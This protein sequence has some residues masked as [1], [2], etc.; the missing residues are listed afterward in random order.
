[1]LD[2]LDIRRNQ[3]L[4]ESV[5]PKQLQNAFR[6]MERNGN[7]W[8]LGQDSRLDWAKDLDLP[9]I[10]INPKP[11]ILWWVG[12]APASEA[13][14]QK[15][16]REFVRILR[17]AKVNFAVLGTREQCTGDSA[18]RAGNEYLFAQMAQANIETLNDVQPPRIVTTCPHCLHT[19]ANEYP[20]FGGNYQ[21]IHHTQLISELVEA[22]R[23]KLKPQALR[24]VA[25]HDPCYLG[26]H[27]GIFDAPR[28]VLQQSGV[29]LR[30]LPR[31]RNRSLCCGA[32]GAQMWKE[33]EPGKE[34]VSTNRFRE[35]QEAGAKTLA[36]GCPFCMIMLS[37][38]SRAAGETIPV[39]DV[40]DIVADAIE[41]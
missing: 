24:D 7:P 32:G 39:R 41:Q 25:F 20:A 35:V 11:E 40:A 3:V 19:I 13:R 10:D 26:R 31:R 4:M 9:T 14:A 15:A 12:C 5:F 16:A 22:G 8:S 21:V 37:D 38:A 30:E 34:K 6:G 23:L 36:V 28:Q 27:N 29:D 33:D 17:A 2:I 18:R 1:M